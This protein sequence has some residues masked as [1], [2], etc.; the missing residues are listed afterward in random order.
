ME[1]VVSDS[2]HSES[3][4]AIYNDIST[5]DSLKKASEALSTSFDEILKVT[6]AGNKEINFW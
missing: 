3:A 6:L 1:D 2:L 4:K 5:E